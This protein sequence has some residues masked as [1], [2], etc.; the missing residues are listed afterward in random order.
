MKTPLILSLAI[1]MSAC[2]RKNSSCVTSDNISPPQRVGGYID[3]NAFVRGSDALA[4][5]ENEN[6][7]ESVSTLARRCTGEFKFYQSG[8]VKKVDVWT[9]RSCYMGNHRAFAVTIQV[10]D[11]DGY[12]PITL[13]PHSS[14]LSL[15]ASNAEHHTEI[16]KFADKIAQTSL[17][18]GAKSQLLASKE[19]DYLNFSNPSSLCGASSSG[20]ADVDIFCLYPTQIAVH[21]FE[22]SSHA[23]KDQDA[24]AIFNTFASVASPKGQWRQSIIDLDE[25]SQKVT[26]ARIYAEISNANS[27]YGLEIKGSTQ[28]RTLLL[29]EEPDNAGKNIINN[30]FLGAQ[31]YEATVRESTSSHTATHLAP[32]WKKNFAQTTLANLK[33]FFNQEKG[34]SET[35]ISS[36]K[37]LS[38]KLDASKGE[39]VQTNQTFVEPWNSQTPKGSPLS[40]GD[41]IVAVLESSEQQAGATSVT[42]LPKP[43]IAP[44]ERKRSD[45]NVSV[46]QPVTGGG[47]S[48]CR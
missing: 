1:L 17:S 18:I 23:D 13:K 44:R 4:N 46:G 33:L 16:R 38:L 26:R 36:V 47:A 34:F 21:T 9:N 2:S 25:V 14:M 15:G 41:T 37:G 42:P 48:N 20:R 11:G 7:P 28:A 27:P 22:F 3:F 29:N 30:Q 8:N 31:A 43:S 12:Y 45:S 32:L 19:M 40:V 24:V 6:V 39:L 5:L 35:P 10:S